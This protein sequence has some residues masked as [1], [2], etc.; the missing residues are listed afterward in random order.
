MCV[1]EYRVPVFEFVIWSSVEIAGR[2]S[3][4]KCEE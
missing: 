3:R 2:Y 4:V 1:S